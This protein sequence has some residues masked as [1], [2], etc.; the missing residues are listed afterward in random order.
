MTEQQPA[1]PVYRNKRYKA[2]HYNFDLFMGPAAGEQFKDCTFID[3]NTGNPVKISDFTGKWLVLETASSTCSMYTKNVPDMKE[4]V[5]EFTDVEFLIVYVR[6]AHPGERLRQHET[7]EEKMAAAG[8]T[9][10]RYGEHRRIVVDNLDGDYHRAYG[11]MPNTLY[12]IRPDGTIHYRC[13]WAAPHL[14]K[15]ALADREHY[16]RVE[17][18]PLMELRASRKAWHMFYTMWAGGFVALYDFFMGL[19]TVVSKHKLTDNYYNKHGRFKQSPDQ[20]IPELPEAEADSND[21]KPAAAE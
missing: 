13:N 17:N 16:H 3:L 4:L 7:M 21:A 9:R 18:A 1:A 14:V 6:E 5:E 8:L 10:S 11:A 20:E 2:T 19:P 12:I 15:K